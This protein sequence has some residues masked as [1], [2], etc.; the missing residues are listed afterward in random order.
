MDPGSLLST[1]IELGIFIYML[2]I[3]YQFLPDPGVSGSAANKEYFDK[4][5]K[6]FKIGGVAGI[7]YVV[8]SVILKLL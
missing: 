8:F 3:G 7:I 2:G 6:L 1:V 5:R 4:Y